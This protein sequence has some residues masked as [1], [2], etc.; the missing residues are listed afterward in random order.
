MFE[1]NN[2][3]QKSP[4]HQWTSNLFFILLIIDL[5][6]LFFLSLCNF[7]RLIF[8][9]TLNTNV[10]IEH[11]TCLLLNIEGLDLKSEYQIIS[12][13]LKMNYNIKYKIHWFVTNKHDSYTLHSLH[14][15]LCFQ[16]DSICFRL[17]WLRN[18][19]RTEFYSLGRWYSASIQHMLEELLILQCWYIK[20]LLVKRRS[21][22]V[23]L[24]PCD[25]YSNK[26][27]R[28]ASIF[29]TIFKQLN[30]RILSH[31][32]PYTYNKNIWYISL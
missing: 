8:L 1:N 29:I 28:I 6:I 22:S 9:S 15:Y 31:R 20:G 16:I 19:H 30:Y 18:A 23:F 27:M 11:W 12:N 25:W 32:L 10:Y 5:L 2:G 17:N 3:F 24:V 7:Q 4:Q 21:P 13:E 26:L 14:N